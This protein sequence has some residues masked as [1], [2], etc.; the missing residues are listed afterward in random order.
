MSEKEASFVDRYYDDVHERLVYIGKRA[1][2][3][4]WDS[5]WAPTDDAIRAAL[6]PGRGTRWLVQLTRRYL[7]IGSGRILEGGC[8]RGHYVSALRQAGYATAGIDFAPE[9]VAAL[10]RVAPELGVL[11][12]DLRSLPFLDH[13][14]AGYWSLGV[15]EHFYSGYQ[16]LAREMTRV[17][18]PGGYLFLTFPCMSPIRKLVARSGGY[19]VL[20]VPE[21]PSGFYQFALNP[22][23]V[24]ADFEE[25]GFR[26]RYQTSMS[27]LQGLKDE[28]GILGR[29][30][31]ALF[32]YGGR[33]IILR[34]IRAFIDRLAPLGAGHSC[35][36]VL[37][38]QSEVESSPPH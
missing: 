4:M 13:A 10:N 30:L 28:F 29:P 7:P 8:G 26:R 9:T 15:I 14:F 6:V 31:K 16:L 3:E 2:P 12:G 32:E 17:I 1:T 22:R 25:L 21:E 34:G 23:R 20:H 18:R 19:P 24:V 37:Q 36:L 5:L 38:K 27:G 11:L 35:V 33:S